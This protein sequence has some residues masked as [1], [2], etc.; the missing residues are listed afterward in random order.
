[1]LQRVFSVMSAFR[2]TRPAAIKSWC[3]GKRDAW[4][5]LVTGTAIFHTVIS[6]FYFAAAVWMIV[7]YAT[8]DVD[9]PRPLT[10]LLVVRF[11]CRLAQFRS[12]RSF[13]ITDRIAYLIPIVGFNTYRLVFFF[14]PTSLP[15]C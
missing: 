15:V 10:W 9:C 4:T 6:G 7:F 12:N 14:S 5:P 2:I 8:T 13:C 11:L 3:S 1:M